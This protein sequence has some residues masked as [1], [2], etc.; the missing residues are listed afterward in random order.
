MPADDYLDPRTALF[1]GGFVAFL[2]WFAGGLAYVAAGEVLPTVRTFA[3][4][5]VGLGFVFFGGG[6]VVALV[7]RWRAGD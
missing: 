6:A 5:F 1:V 7:L 4:V 3:L 2:F